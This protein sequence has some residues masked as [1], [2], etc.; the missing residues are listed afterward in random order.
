M[1]LLPHR[2]S[3]AG[4]FTPPTRLGFLWRIRVPLVC[5]LSGAFLSL[6]TNGSDISWISSGGGDFHS[7]GNWSPNAVPG[8]NDAALFDVAMS[9]DV[10]LSAGASPGRIEFGTDATSFSLGAL[11]GS[12]LTFSNGGDISILSNLVLSNQTFTINAPLVLTPD[13]AT[14]PGSFT[15]RNDASSPTSVLSLAGNLSSGSTTGIETLTLRGT[16]TGANTI[17]GVISNGGASALSLTKADAGTW[18]LSGA[19][20]F[21]GGTSIEGGILRLEGG[22]NRL[23]STGSLAFGGSSGTLDVGSNSQTLG[24][25][26]FSKT[27]TTSHLIT[28]ATG[29]LQVNGGDIQ[30]G[31]GDTSA[32]SAA[33]TVDM[34]GLGNFLFV[35]SLKS[36]SV[37]GRTDNASA[38]VTG[39]GTLFLAKT[40]SITASTF[41]ISPY[42]NGNSSSNSGTVHLG[43]TNTINANSV[44]I[45]GLKTTALLD[46]QTLTNPIL[47]IRGT[48]GTDSNRAVMTVG[49]NNSGILEANATVDLTSGGTVTS[50]LDALLSSLVIGQNL[51]STN[52]LGKSVTGTFIMG[53]GLLDAT[54]IVVAGQDSVSLLTT[55]S[56]DA[57]GSLTLNGGTI[58]TSSLTLADKKT[59]AAATPQTITSNFTLNSGT[60]AATLIQRGGAGTGAGANSATIHFNWV[61]GTISNLTGIDQT[62]SGNTA[63]NGLTGGLNIVL[64]NIGNTSGTHTWEVSSAR[65]STVQNTVTLSGAGGLT[66]SG[67]GRLILNGSNSYSGVTQINEGTL[68]FGLLS[69][70]TNGSTTAWTAQTL[71]VASGATA[72]FNVGGTGEFTPT[73]VDFLLGLSASSGEFA[74]G[75]FLELDTTNAPGEVI[76]STL[77]QNS[78]GGSNA[79]GLVKSGS[80][81]L[82][83]TGSNSYTG[84][85]TI[86]KGVLKL[87][88]GDNR[89]LS[90]GKLTF[91]GLSGTL[92]VGATHQTL[93]GLTFD[94]TGTNA[95][96]VTGTGSL[97]V[98]AGNFLLGGGDASSTSFSSSLDMSG[99]ESFVYDRSTG[100]F[101]VGGKSDSALGSTIANGELTLAAVNTITAASFN[102]G[103]YG[104]SQSAHNTG[105][106][107][108]GQTNEVN[109]STFLVGNQKTTSLL[110]F[111][112][113]VNPTLK[114]RGTAGTNS[115]RA[116]ITV[117][118][119]GSGIRAAVATIDLT[120]GG[121]VSSTLDA[122][123]STLLIGQVLRDGSPGFS[124]TGS[125]LMGLGTLDAT[126]IILGQQIAVTGANSSSDSIATLS[127]NGGTISAST[128]TLADKRS[129]A[130]AQTI[131]STFNLNSGVLKATTIQR[132]TAGTGAGADSATIHFNWVDGTIGN[133][134]GTN[135][136]VR[137]NTAVNGLTGGLNIVLND[138]GNVSGTHTLEVSNSKTATFEDTV[139]LSGTG[140][141]TKT[142]DGVL[143]FNGTST[144]SGVVTVAEGTLG[145]SGI[146]SGDTSVSAGAT[147][148]AGKIGTVNAPI[149]ADLGTLQ[150]AGNLTTPTG[151]TWLVDLVQGVSGSAD[152]IEVGNH[153]DLSDSSL[154][155]N[156]GGTFQANKVYTIATYGSSL[157][158]TFNGLNE[159]NFLGPGNLYFINYGSGP[160]G[161]ITLT[162]VPEP[163]TLGLLGM[164]FG[165]YLFRR[166][167]RKRAR[168]TT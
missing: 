130:A 104:T 71:V 153:L 93:A 78:N 119:N 79:I 40:N 30:I 77:I 18:T 25:L 144:S 85:T 50:T 31:G 148:T 134:D 99:L 126:S 141:L 146:I 4:R 24:G 120:S 164:A 90:S 125:F 26:T 81:T 11:N 44:V 14:T 2:L 89:L 10:T 72:A 23:L 76:Y 154:V 151:A 75:S 147:I 61:D 29:T 1:K 109:A 41:G 16:N 168:S 27:G 107:H 12:S 142:G 63:V 116:A 55:A 98:T 121:T 82:T 13:S 112:N 110:D 97:S 58:R 56:G 74:N 158:G 45:G 20:T 114:I 69:S 8:F 36:F 32:V 28:G 123:V 43:Q 15:V 19:N 35:N 51:R 135:L 65:I 73:E 131:T 139:V 167:W 6:P 96:V 122:M 161:A 70:L 21:T 137:G 92:D 37:G 115:S 155:V 152:R 34:S 157:T 108:L 106:V 88:G 42:G 138:T 47:K 156:F 140:N 3:P 64:N 150:I 66:K 60:L 118:I 129:G 33:Q 84:N 111:Q 95:H 105:T 113:L 49:A 17:G 68:Q 136:T 166:N 86:N 53:A 100:R 57:T 117:G 160:N 127:L 48:G 132:G 38:A 80:G 159:G 46:F 87:T 91:S 94:S 149:S 128:F 83:L 103:F 39:S 133:I 102:V 165:G 145:G 124:A 163:G 162:A 59:N 67:G 54:S 101:D 143:L 52:A 5:F 9:G 7:S 62:V 22:N